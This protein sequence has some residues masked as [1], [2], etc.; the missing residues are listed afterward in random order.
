M[1]YLFGIMQQKYVHIGGHAVK[2]DGP[3]LIVYISNAY[4]IL[5]ISHI[6]CRVG[7][8]EQLHIIEHLLLQQHDCLNAAA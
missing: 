2:Y 1:I 3:Q 5:T 7:R 8:R 6:C 4:F